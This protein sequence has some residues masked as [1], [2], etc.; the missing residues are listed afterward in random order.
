M[1]NTTQNPNPN[2]LAKPAKRHIWKVPLPGTSIEKKITRPGLPYF[3][4]GERARFVLGEHP[5][6][7]NS[8]RFIL[9]QVFI[10]NK[11]TP[12]FSEH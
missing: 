2:P 3:T 7:V 12:L 11:K 10:L 1:V 6:S 9:S 5:Y 4:I 8:E